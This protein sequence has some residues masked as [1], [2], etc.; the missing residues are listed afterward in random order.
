MSMT[1]ADGIFLNAEAETENT[2]DVVLLDVRT[3]VGTAFG[4]A[5]DFVGEEGS[6]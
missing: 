2:S 6:L 3:G 5:G 4:L 1:R